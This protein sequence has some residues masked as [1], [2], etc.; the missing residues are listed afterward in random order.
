MSTMTAI[1]GY[2]V[3]C[4]KVGVSQFLTH[5]MTYRAGL[6]RIHLP[7][8]TEIAVVTGHTVRDLH[9]SV[10]TYI[11]LNYYSDLYRRVLVIPHTINLGAISTEQVLTVQVWNANRKAIHLSSVKVSNGEGITIQAVAIPKKVQALAITTWTVRISM[12]GPAVF[13]AQVIWTIL[14]HSPVTL[15]I[16]GSRSTSWPFFPNWA[17]D[18]VENLD[19]LTAVHQS[20]SGAEQ[21]IARRLSPRRT[22]EF[23]TL[24]AG[25]EKQ[26]FDNALYAYGSRVWAMPIFTD[27]TILKRAVQ[28]KD[29]VIHLAITGRDFTVD[30]QVLLMAQGGRKETVEISAIE[31]NKLHLKRPIQR[32]YEIGTTVYPIRSAILTDPPTIRRLSDGVSGA[33][34]RLAIIEHNGWSDDVSHL[35]AYRGFPV[36][37]PTSDLSEELTSHYARLIAELDNLT[38]KVHRLDTAQKTFPVYAHQFVLN[39]RDEQQKMRQLFYYLRGRQ[40]TIWVSTSTT[41]FY[42]VKDLV[43]KTLDVVHSGYSSTLKNETG[44]QDIRIELVN[45]RVF[46]RRIVSAEVVDNNTERLA[47]DGESISVK[48]SDIVKISFIALCRLESD[49]VSWSHKTDADGVATVAVNFRG[50]RDELEQ[51]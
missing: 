35:P 47:L 3:P 2:L 24:L 4:I 44:R 39:G 19:F 46:Y 16:T 41:D 28:A 32:D 45:R 34:I 29:S 43:G 31:A 27:G 14:G 7:L 5:A 42:P 9:E 33:Q 30:G 25:V 51:G 40:R 13:D 20:Y 22:F 36:L 11:P 6:P 12:S 23:Q 18:V 48:L 8:K 1:N 38:G 49:T 17:Q 37:E 26:T 10:G 15:N 50:V 21:R